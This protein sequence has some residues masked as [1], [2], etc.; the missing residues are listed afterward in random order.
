[1]KFVVVVKHNNI[2]GL[3]F[4]SSCDKIVALYFKVIATGYASL[5]LETSRVDFCFI[6]DI[7]LKLVNIPF[8]NILSDVMTNINKVLVSYHSFLW[9]KYSVS[10]FTFL[11]K[12]SVS[13]F[14][15]L[16]SPII[17]LKVQSCQS[18]IISSIKNIHLKQIYVWCLVSP[19]G[20]SNVWWL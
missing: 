4:C 15:F 19:S 9:Y 1:M 10:L 20:F 7:N 2:L 5:V 12:Y 17:L 3:V 6:I 13:L 16:C 18:F 14:T 11:Y 8:L